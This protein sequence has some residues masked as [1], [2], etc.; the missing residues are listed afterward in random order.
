MGCVRPNTRGIEIFLYRFVAKGCASAIEAVAAAAAA[1][2]EVARTERACWC[3]RDGDGCSLARSLQ[4][5]CLAVV[6]SV[7]WVLRK[8]AGSS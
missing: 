5:V 4:R 8:K 2:L 6:E 3:Y 1:A 7:V